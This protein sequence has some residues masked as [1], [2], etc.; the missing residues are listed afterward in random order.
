MSA[1][2]MLFLLKELLQ[3]LTQDSSLKSK[4]IYYSY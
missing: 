2:I 4:G 1:M 3:I